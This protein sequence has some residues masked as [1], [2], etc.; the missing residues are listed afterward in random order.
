MA[1]D[2]LF[3]SQ[4]FSPQSHNPGGGSPSGRHSAEAAPGLY[5]APAF[6]T[7]TY[8]ATANVTDSVGDG[9]IEVTDRTLTV[10][11]PGDTLSRS[12]ASS[13]QR[14]LPQQVEPPSDFP[15]QKLLNCGSSS[16]P[17]SGWDAGPV[18]RRQEKKLKVSVQMENGDIGTH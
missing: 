5:D 7:Q 15:K 12:T 9:A 16:I 18:F 6:Y 14:S 1:H 3:F 13:P 4:P 2:S 10:L 17:C 8:S 11:L